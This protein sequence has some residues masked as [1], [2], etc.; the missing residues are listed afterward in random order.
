MIKSSRHSQRPRGERYALS[1]ER[2]KTH[3]VHSSLIHARSS[4]PGEVNMRR[5]IV[6]HAVLNALALPDRHGRVATGIAIDGCTEA[7]IVTALA[8]RRRGGYIDGFALTDEGR[9]L[10]TSL[11]LTD[12]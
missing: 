2:A 10:L 3:N 9:R 12:P 8:E 11:G 6:L 7:E 1:A 5:Q 4:T